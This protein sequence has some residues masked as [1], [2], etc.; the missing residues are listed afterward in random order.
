M[1]GALSVSS[2]GRRIPKRMLVAPMAKPTRAMKDPI[3]PFPTLY[4]VPEVHPPERTIPIPKMNPPMTTA[5]QKK[6]ATDIL[7]IA[8]S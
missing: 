7:I 4:Q 8:N 1:T 2:N 5:G 3:I 6:G